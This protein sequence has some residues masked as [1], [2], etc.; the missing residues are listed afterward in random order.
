MLLPQGLSA[1][2]NSYLYSFLAL[3]H[4][5]YSIQTLSPDVS[6]DIN[7]AQK[8]YSILKMRCYCYRDL[9]HLVWKCLVR[10]DIRQL[11]VE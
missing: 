8:T 4:L 9:S 1:M 7:T 6:I 10:I 5:Y 11:T 2:L 3:A